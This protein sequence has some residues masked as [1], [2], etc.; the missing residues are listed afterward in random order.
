M[1]LNEDDQDQKQE[2]RASKWLKKARSKQTRELRQLQREKRRAAEWLRYLRY[3]QFK[4]E[5]SLLQ[6][7][8]QIEVGSI[9]A[10]EL[11]IELIELDPKGIPAE[12][13]ESFAQFKAQLE[14]RRNARIN[15]G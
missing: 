5:Y 2:W 6:L 7:L 14:Q 12:H 4:G 8:N 15:H 10:C 9:L 1:K 13:S 3:T 11:A